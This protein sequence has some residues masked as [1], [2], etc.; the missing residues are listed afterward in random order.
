MHLQRIK[1]EKFFNRINKTKT[2]WL[3]I[4]NTN[5]HGYGRMNI[6]QKQ[7]QS[8]RLMWEIKFGPI[9]AGLLVCHKCDVRHCVNPDHLFLGTNLDNMRDM[10]IKKRS[11]NGKKTHCPFGHEYN[12][13]NVYLTK[14][15]QRNYRP[16]DLRRKNM[17]YKKCQEN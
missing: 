9:P 4:G 12:K 8:H 1:L 3:W 15:N 14:R 6:K 11:Y 16:C 13:E 10:A 2:C 7:E 5:N 17:R